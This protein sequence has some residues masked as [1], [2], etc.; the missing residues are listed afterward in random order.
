MT[1]EPD[2]NTAKSPAPKR[3]GGGAPPWAWVPTLYIAEGLPYVLVMVVSTIM[4]TRL[5]ASLSQIGFWTSLLG[6]AWVLKPLWGPLVDLYWT[7]R[8][9]TVLMQILMGI[10]LGIVAFTLQGPLWWSG[11]L[12]ALAIV[13]LLS[14]THDIAADGFYMDALNERQQ[15][16]YVGIRSTFYR[17][18]M[19][20]GQGVLL[21]IAGMIEERTGPN[22][23]QLIVQGSEAT[24]DQVA[25]APTVSDDDFVRFEPAFATL[26]PGETTTVTVAL[27]QPPEGDQTVTLRREASSFW[28]QLF[29]IGLE[30]QISL[31][32]DTE[33]ITFNADNWNVPQPVVFSA[34]ENLKGTVRA[35]FVAASGNLPLTWGICFGGIGALLLGIGVFHLVTLPRPAADFNVAPTTPFHIAAMVMALVVA[36]PIGLYWLAFSGISYV[37]RWLAQLRWGQEL[38]FADALL[39]F[40]TIAIIVAIVT[41][42][43]RVRTVRSEVGG[44][45]SSAARI[46]NVPF[47][48]VFRSFF[49]KPG[50][51]PMLTFL[52]VYRL[53]EAMLVKMSGPFLVMPV[54]E[55]GMGLSSQQYGFAYGMTG[56]I[57]M[58]AGGILGGWVASRHGLKRWLL[59]MCIAINLPDLFYVYLAHFQPESFAIVVACVAGETFGYGF[60]FTAYMLYMLYIAGSGEHK[61]SHFALCTGFMALGMMLPGM[62]S[63]DLAEALGWTWFFILVCIATIPGFIMLAFIPLEDE[64][65]RRQS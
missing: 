10:L 43:L 3:D 45:F 41:A 48:E 30:Q 62:I 29:P 23:V 11:S 6:F 28:A 31:S 33:V 2:N 44:M 12:L 39:S 20:F 49:A 37:L 5:G 60:G 25:P 22:P 51:V 19:I 65:G 16:F 8:R 38:P 1:T 57:T 46:S 14:A 64:F 54:S 58:T 53:G 56:V 18:S 15:A 55:G 61:T 24:A 36:I 59:P 52:L 7:K 63:G 35:P 17:I 47:D 42:L 4:Y 21:I 40:V 34:D 27:S 9:W 50:I 32:K 26:A 13:A